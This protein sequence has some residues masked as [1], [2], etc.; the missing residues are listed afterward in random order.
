MLWAIALLLAVPRCWACGNRN[1]II[2]PGQ[3]ERNRELGR[4]G[5]LILPM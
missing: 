5:W 1:L 4:N 3:P 2:I